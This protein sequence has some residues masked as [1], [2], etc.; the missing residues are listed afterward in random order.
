LEKNA[1]LTTVP[2]L[3]QS[4]VSLSIFR[5][6]SLSALEGKAVK[7]TREAFY[8]FWG[9]G[10]F[11]GTTTRESVFWNAKC[12]LSLSGMKQQRKVIL[13]KH[14]TFFSPAVGEQLSV[15]N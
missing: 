14:S 2:Y 9:I 4:P 5:E 1:A 15:R 7:I 3:V 12:T 11:T 8:V 10:R 6:F 13:Q